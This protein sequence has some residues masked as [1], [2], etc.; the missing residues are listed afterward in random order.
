MRSLIR[1]GCPLTLAIALALPSAPARAQFAGGEQMMREFAPMIGV[2]HKKMGKKRVGR[3][4]HS[5]GPMMRKVGPIMTSLMRHGGGI[6]SL[7]GFGAFGGL[8]GFD[9]GSFG[10]GGFGA[11]RDS[12]GGSRY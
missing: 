12:G 6:E 4:A 2:M 3:L 9:L 1:L 10:F 8:G 7:G 11:G 5:I